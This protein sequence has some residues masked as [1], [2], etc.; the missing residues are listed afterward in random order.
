M[1][2]KTLVDF[3]SLFFNKL[4]GGEKVGENR[5]QLNIIP[6]PLDRRLTALAA[7]EP[8]LVLSDHKK[9]LESLE[10]IPVLQVET[11][12]SVNA[13]ASKL[14]FF[15]PRVIFLDSQLTWGDPLEIVRELNHH[16]DTP[17]ILLISQKKQTHI[18]KAAYQAGISDVLFAPYRREDILEALSVLLKLHVP[19]SLHK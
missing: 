11:A 13:L 14:M 17:I 4:R 19:K 6:F 15:K 8:I 2:L 7:R 3:E 12:R 5:R 9:C 10:S 16:E 18:L 1:P